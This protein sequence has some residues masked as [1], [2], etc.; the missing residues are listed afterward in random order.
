M[1]GVPGPCRVRPMTG[2]MTKITLELDL[3]VHGDRIDGHVDA[4]EG[5][6]EP[7]V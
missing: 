7:F 5:T 3:E 1:P 6:K 2:C 4:G